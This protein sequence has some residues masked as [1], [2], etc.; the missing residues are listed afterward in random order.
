M[1]NKAL[2]LDANI[3]F[4]SPSAIIAISALLSLA[5]FSYSTQGNALTYMTYFI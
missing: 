2:D 1:K 3:A 4:A 5:Y